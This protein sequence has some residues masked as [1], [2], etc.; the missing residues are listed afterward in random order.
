MY[1]VGM[2]PH[3]VDAQTLSQD[4]IV[5]GIPGILN[6]CCSM[7]PLC[8]R[9]P[10]MTILEPS[11]CCSLRGLRRKRKSANA[12]EVNACDQLTG[13]PWACDMFRC[14][15]KRISPILPFRIRSCGRCFF[16]S[17]IDP[18]GPA[19]ASRWT[20]ENE[21]CLS[22]LLLRDILYSASIRCN[23]VSCFLCLLPCA[24]DA[25]RTWTKQK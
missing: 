5:T 4:I 24:H 17:L 22:V 15:A 12:E 16:L 20:R 23:V 18:P 2:D 13:S 7:F 14:F 9:R 1:S 8:A 11:H 21:G 6:T 19:D 25:P 10:T 3:N